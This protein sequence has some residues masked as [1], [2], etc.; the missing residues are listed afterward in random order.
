MNLSGAA[1]FGLLLLRVSGL[2]LAL[3]HG[4]GKVQALAAGET[5]F[6][7]RVAGLGFPAPALF[8]WTAALSEFAG[9]LLVFIGLGTRS[10]AAFA[11]A[12]MAVA[13]FWRHRGFEQ[14]LAD[15]GLVA[16]T[17]ERRDQLGNPEP[18]TVLFLVFM[19]LVFT[20]AGRFSL[21]GFFT[22]DRD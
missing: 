2:I 3:F 22:R 7:E 13:A 1:S 11:A 18:A 12:T 10:A 8:A 6:I 15:A 17:P 4:L 9:G 16:M 20:G 19:T 5:G 21:D 14:W